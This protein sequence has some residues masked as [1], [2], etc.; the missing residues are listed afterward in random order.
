[1][2]LRPPSISRRHRPVPADLAPLKQQPQ[3][4]TLENVMFALWVLIAVAAAVQVPLPGGERSNDVDSSLVPFVGGWTAALDALGAV[5][6]PRWKARLNAMTEQ[7]LAW[8]R[9]TSRRVRRSC[10]ASPFP[11][12]TVECQ[13]TTSSMRRNE[14]PCGRIAGPRPSAKRLWTHENNPNRPSCVRLR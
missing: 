1:M 10:C 5:P 11:I 4:G 13:G 3:S 9:T 14:M 12:C 8:R 6:E 2:Y 7:R